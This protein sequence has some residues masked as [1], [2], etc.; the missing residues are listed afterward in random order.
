MIRFLGKIVSNLVA[1]VFAACLLI[2]GCLFV[3]TAAMKGAAEAQKNGGGNVFEA[4]KNSFSAS[5]ADDLIGQY[6][7]VKNDADE[8]AKAIRAGAVAEMYLQAKDQ[9]NYRRW[10]DIADVHQ[11]K[12]LGK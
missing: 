10:K 6:N 12:A 9:G 8:M 4:A 5:V 11:R 7:I 1:M 2:G 3:G